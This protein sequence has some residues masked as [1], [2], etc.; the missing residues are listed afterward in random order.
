MSTTVVRPRDESLAAALRLASGFGLL[1]FVFH[2]A[3]N[4]LQRHLGY[5]YFRDEMYYLMC[6]RH[7]AWGYVDHGP[8]VA[9]QAR[10]AETLFGD[11]LAGIRM[12]SGLAGAARIF[13]TGLLAWSLGGRRPAQ[14][15]AMT[16][17][18]VAPE[19]LAL[20]GFLSM[21][22]VESIFWMLCLLAVI[23][24]QRGGSERL[25]LL[26]GVAGGLGLLNKPSM[27]FF[28]VALLAGL[29]LTPQRRLLASRWA[30]I[31]VGVLI[32][33]AL[34]NLLW[35]IHNHWP[36][37][38]FLSNGR[39]EHKNVALPPLAFLGAQIVAL[40]PLNLLLWGAGVVWLVR[41]AAWR[42]AGI[43]Y[44]L[45]LAAMMAMHAK[46]YY[47]MPVYP[48]L[49]AAGGIAWEG[50]YGKS[51]G[52]QAGRRF[53]F[54]VLQTAL[55]VTGLIILPL[56][57]PIFTPPTWLAY[58]KATHLYNIGGN[59]ENTENGPLPQFF[60][61][62]FGWQEEVDEITRIYN[63]L[64]P[65]DR[66]RTAI[67]CSNYGEASA[68]NMLGH[69][70]PTAISGHNNYYLW[71]TH[72]ATGEVVI[73]VSGGTVADMQENYADVQIAGRMDHPLAMPYEHRNIYLLRH[74]KLNLTADWL[75][76]KHYI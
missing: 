72:G 44:L 16:G 26:F 57:T 53:A 31:G 51:R 62:R 5:G 13:L 4:L 43:A 73:V 12:L 52:V 14:A 8:L 1:V 20:D 38:E 21:N 75:A 2:V 35:Q 45:F 27:T 25:W 19:Y 39:K 23:L 71:G 54:P 68:I 48:V 34:P 41:N 6:G 50:F 42:W 61:D 76:L 11:S 59:S 33:I 67:L 30:A 58:T 46:D 28:L 56:S 7:L 69:G 29:L 17:V 37:L 3:M 63:S 15:L 70:L 36:T 10:L 74:R 22:S 24:I 18:L 60:A 40:H 65:E 47:V 55:V 49:F 32:L 9:V 64:S 66:A